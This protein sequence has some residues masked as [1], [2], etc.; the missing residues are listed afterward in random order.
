MTINEIRGQRV[1]GGGMWNLETE[2][3]VTAG[4]GTIVYAQG[5][6]DGANETYT[7][8]NGSVFDWLTGRGG[9]TG[10]RPYESYESLD[11]ADGTEYYDVFVTLR[12]V[13]K[14]LDVTDDDREVVVTFRD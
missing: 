6:S 11:D 12:A 1:G 9:D 4:D 5:S 13:M 2:A 14:V 8:S 7:L 3:T 10:V